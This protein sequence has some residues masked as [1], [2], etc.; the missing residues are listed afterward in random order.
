MKE[1]VGLKEAEGVFDSNQCVRKST[2]GR[3]SMRVMTNSKCMA[4]ELRLRYNDQQ[5]EQKVSKSGIDGK[6]G[7]CGGID[8]VHGPSWKTENRLRSLDRF[9]MIM[10]ILKSGKF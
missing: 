10:G 6:H 7:H 3:S 2:G 8:G 9:A 1:V 4:D 5:A